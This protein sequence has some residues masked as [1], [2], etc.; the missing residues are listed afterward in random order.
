MTSVI[1]SY[2]LITSFVSLSRSMA[3][4]IIF[5]YLTHV[6]NLTL[7]LFFL[8]FIPEGI[9]PTNI[10]I[11]SQIY[12]IF[13]LI[14]RALRNRPISFPKKLT[15]KFHQNKI[16]SILIIL[17][18]ADILINVYSV[19]IYPPVD[20]D[21]LAYHLQAPSNWFQAKNLDFFPSNEQRTMLLSDNLNFLS[22]WLSLSFRSD[23]F[24]EIAPYSMLIFGSL[25]IF[26]F[27]QN[28]YNNPSRNFILSL[29][30]YYGGSYLGH[31]SKNFTGDVGLTAFIFSSLSLLFAY[32][33][34]R[35]NAIFFYFSLSNGLLLGTKSL[36][37][38]SVFLIYLL[39]VFIEISARKGDNWKQ[40]IMKYFISIIIC[41]LVG[42]F[43]YF[44]NIYYFHNPFYGKEIVFFGLVHLPGGN[45]QAYQAFGMNIPKAFELGY[46]LFKKLLSGAL[47]YQITLLYLPATITLFLFFRNK[48]SRLVLLVA[49]YPIILSFISLALFGDNPPRY[50]FSLNLTGIASLA[51]L[52]KLIKNKNVTKLGYAMV[53]VFLLFFSSQKILSNIIVKS[54][55]NN[56]LPVKPEANPYYD[57]DYYFFFKNIPQGTTLVYLLPENA[58]IYPLY[59]SRYENRLIYA[60][61]HDYDEIISLFKKS[62]AEYFMSKKPEGDLSNSFLQ[63][64]IGRNSI[65]NTTETQI[66]SIVAELTKNDLLTQI[67]SGTRI[68][69][70]KINSLNVKN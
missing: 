13:S 60:N 5:T 63:T 34:Q 62:K 8:N 65:E 68:N 47:G 3:E 4:K 18:L 53:I 64:D 2:F 7:I 50:F 66:Y 10:L 42:G 56:N 38:L 20:P 27:L 67:G 14:L 45:L 29:L 31:F 26:Y 22:L 37:F 16:I 54:L 33:R 69:Y 35:S 23:F 52:L 41:L 48:V 28:L 21:T 36:A 57:G 30:Y 17:L 43:Y 40:I 11:A 6:A 58:F 61:I 1:A 46:D 49:L 70:Y 51:I 12:L 25:A 9:T 15:I 19:Y 39:A 59:G 32:F 24:I 55:F 44:R